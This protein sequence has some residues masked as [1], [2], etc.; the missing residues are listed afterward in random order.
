M[1]QA[2]YVLP[3]LHQTKLYIEAPISQQLFDNE[4]AKALGPDNP[5]FFLLY[6]TQYGSKVQPRSRYSG[7]V[8]AEEFEEYFGPF[9]G[10][11][12]FA[13]RS[14]S[15]WKVLDANKASKFQLTQIRGIGEQTAKAIVDKRKER[16]YDGPS[17]LCKRVRL[18]DPSVAHLFKYSKKK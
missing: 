1:H 8:A 7:I 16:D 3:E 10:R 14:E 9:T 11:A 5:G 6:T 2:D 13:S 12:F 17:D 18:K 4:L 15:S